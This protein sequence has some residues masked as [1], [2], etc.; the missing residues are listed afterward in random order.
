MADVMKVDRAYI[1]PSSGEDPCPE[2]GPVIV[3]YIF[4]P[5]ETEMFIYLEFKCCWDVGDDNVFV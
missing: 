2:D 3:G 4:I 5:E 1:R